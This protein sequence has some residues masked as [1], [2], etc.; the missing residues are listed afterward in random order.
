MSSD[1]SPAVGEATSSAESASADAEAAIGVGHGVADDPQAD[2]PW[3]TPGPKTAAEPISWDDRADGGMSQAEWFLRTGRA[4]LHPD[5]ETSWDEDAE[6]AAAGHHEV[7]VT[8]AGV[9][10]WAGETTDESASTPPPWENGPWPG[11]DRLSAPGS[12][13][14]GG[15]NGEFRPSAAR[16]ASLAGSAA[17]ASAAPGATRPVAAPVRWPARTVVTAGLI[18]LVVP[19]LVLGILSLRQAG[20]QSIR[21]A[22][23]LAIGASVAWAMII[24]VIVAGISGGSAGSCGDYPTAVHQAYEKA[25]SDLTDNAPATVQ[26]ADL[27]A[28]ASLANA[29]AAAT[30]QIGVRTALFTMA[31]DMA[32]ARS[33][34]MARRPIPAALRQ[35]MTEDGAL[36]SGS[37]GS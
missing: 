2:D 26:A 34:V 36:P 14:S 6:A 37:C 35:H 15:S 27:E 19:G 22:S 9:P 20:G 29:S 8:A 5:S 12:R 1:R 13:A 33:D 32:Q 30:G 28:A 11:P 17:P 31:N 23:W 24:I 18:P 25:L 4:G 21:R 10:P 16:T 7:R 3:F